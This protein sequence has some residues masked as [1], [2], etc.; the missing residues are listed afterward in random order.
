MS[1]TNIAGISMKGGR[2]DN[3][4]FCLLEHFEDNDRWFLKSLL[5]VK[6]EDGLDGNDAIRTWIESYEITDLVIDFPLSSPECQEC[7]L[8]CPGISRCPQPSVV[9]VNKQIKEILKVDATTRHEN[10]KRYEQERNVDDEVHFSRDIL[11]SDASDHILSRS[12]KR[13]LKKGYL[14]YWNRPIDLFIWNRYY[15][16]LL[17]L[18]KSIYDSFGNTSLMMLSRFAYLRRHFPNS[19]K[20]HE[21]NVNLSLIELLR[22]KVILKKDIINM[23]DLDLGPEARLDIIKKIESSQNVFI[24]DK[25]LETLVKNPRAFDSFILA[26]SGQCYQLSSTRTLP[27]W[28]EP[29]KTR[30][31]IPKF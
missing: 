10:P 16:Q 11:E 29:S 17:H 26:I 28:A 7:T 3:F 31:L 30:F 2:S 6:D 14:P 24:Y 4:I 19:L 12:Y 15:D 9:Q 20:L 27:D 18:F 1:V 8:A 25:D 21:S 23:S 22:A 13:R 5:Q